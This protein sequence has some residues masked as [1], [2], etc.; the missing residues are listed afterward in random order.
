MGT[1]RQQT[2]LDDLT[3]APPLWAHPMRAQ[4]KNKSSQQKKGQKPIK[5]QIAYKIDEHDI[6]KLLTKFEIKKKYDH[7]DINC[8]IK[9]YF[10]TF[11]TFGVAG[12]TATPGKAA[13]TCGFNIFCL[14]RSTCRGRD[15]GLGDIEVTGATAMPG[16]DTRE[17]VGLIGATAILGI[18]TRVDVGLGSEGGVGIWNC[19]TPAT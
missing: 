16:T 17:D 3:Q 11:T 7:T 10:T 5:L 19:T 2:G 12:A 14:E 9:F 1:Q 13:I 8:I 18:N 15:V 4:M 6:T